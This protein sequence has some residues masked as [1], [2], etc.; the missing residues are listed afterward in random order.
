[1]SCSMLLTSFSTWPNV[2]CF[3][4]TSEFDDKQNQASF[5]MFGLA[6]LLLVILANLT[7][8]QERNEQR[9]TLKF[10]VKSG[11]RPIDCWQCLRTV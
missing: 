4:A 8:A 7:K 10:L 5:K 6:V 2:L 11:F 3:V 9:V 1:M